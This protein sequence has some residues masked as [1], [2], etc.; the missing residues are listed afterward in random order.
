MPGDLSAVWKAER[1]TR[2][3]IV[4][5]MIVAVALGAIVFAF[6]LHEE[7]KPLVYTHEAVRIV[8]PKPGD[9]VLRQTTIFVELKS[10]YDVRDIVIQGTAVQRD[11]LEV[12]PGLNRFGYTPGKGKVIEELE[13]LRTCPKV[14]FVNTAVP[15]AALESFEWCFFVS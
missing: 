8:H 3:R 9:Q 13:A 11:D 4:V 10:G 5:T 6:S 1:V 12:I 2:R 7:E 15:G 14:E